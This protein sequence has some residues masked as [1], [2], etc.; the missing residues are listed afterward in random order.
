MIPELLQ[1]IIN[2][3]RQNFDGEPTVIM[4]D[5][6]SFTQVRKAIMKSKLYCEATFSTNVVYDNIPVKSFKGDSGN[7]FKMEIK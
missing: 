3:Y 7:H 6:T 5:L 1:F 4:L 2:S